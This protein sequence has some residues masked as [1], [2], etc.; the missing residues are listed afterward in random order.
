[1]EGYLASRHGGVFAEVGPG[2][3]DYGD[4]VFLVACIR[5]EWVV[6]NDERRKSGDGKERLPSIEFALV[7]CAQSS[8]RFCGIDVHVS[9]DLN[10][11]YTCALDRLSAW[12]CGSQNEAENSSRGRAMSHPAGISLCFSSQP[13]L[14]LLPD[15]FLPPKFDE[16]L[17]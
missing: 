6:V 9:P 5:S 15:I 4:V 7:S 14:I 16:L 3:V 10:L 13:L 11:R 17:V 8:S 2:S 12:N 1:M